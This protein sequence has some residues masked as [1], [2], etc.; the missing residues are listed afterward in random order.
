[1]TIC[2]Y[3]LSATKWCIRNPRTSP[4]NFPVSDVSG[5]TITYPLS[6]STKH[7]KSSEPQFIQEESAQL[8]VMF[9]KSVDIAECWNWKPTTAAGANLLF[10]LWKTA[11]LPVTKVSLRF[12][13]LNGTAYTKLLES[14]KCCSTAR[15]YQISSIAF[16]FVSLNS[17]LKTKGCFMLQNSLKAVY[18]ETFLWLS[19]TVNSL[20]YISYSGLISSFTLWSIHL[21]S[22]LWV[23]TKETLTANLCLNSLLKVLKINVL[24]YFQ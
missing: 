18:G 23:A 14:T 3:T 11:W 10:S 22:P 16:L 24:K 17:F 2:L 21:N 4:K 12:A 8:P 9:L 7:S 6:S 1:M 15:L 19:F 13:A 5:D 20:I